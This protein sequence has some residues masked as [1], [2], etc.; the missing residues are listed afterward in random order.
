MSLK[1]R[2]L[3]KGSALR[4]INFVSKVVIGFVLMPMIMNALGDKIY[5]IWVIIGTFMG[6]Y[7]FFDFGL[8]KAAQRFISQSLGEGSE[9]KTNKT[10]NIFLFL[11]LLISVFLIFISLLVILFARVFITDLG[12]LHVFRIVVLI[13][14]ISLALE[15]PTRVFKGIL[16]SH[17]RY[18]LN[19]IT[20][21]VSDLLRF[22]LVF[23]FV[24]RGGGIVALGIIT[25]TSKIVGN[26]LTIVFACQVFKG[27]KLSFKLVD[28][29]KIKDI[30][31]YSWIVAV[32]NIT[33]MLR[34]RISSFIIV[35][36]MG[37][38]YVTIYAVALRLV[39]YFEQAMIAISGTLMPVFSQY[40]GE[41]NYN[42]IR[43][44][45]LFTSKITCYVSLFIGFILIVF[46]KNF[47]IKW[48][49]ES[50]VEAYVPMVILV[51][52][53]MFSTMQTPGN[54][55]LYGIS[56]H[57]F[58][59]FTNTIEGICNLLL[60]VIFIK[61][62][63]LVGVAFGVAIPLTILKLIV[64]P[65]YICKLIG[66]RKTDYYFKTVLPAIFKSCCFFAVFYYNI[67]SFLSPN[68]MILAVLSLSACVLFSLYV[69]AVGF[70]GSELKYLKKIKDFRKGMR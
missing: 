61:K 30:F 51:S 36:F 31:S 32:S 34:F 52:A 26:I 3:I 20:E 56:K 19:T 67:K 58:F 57:K 53:N 18:D 62:I 55:L 15:F 66:L 47:I 1:A 24:K 45:Y 48:L 28:R 11:Y 43:E 29:S 6:Y 39:E 59:I 10:V 44:K 70:K 9:I 68:Y 16:T 35:G 21:L 38:S 14:S 23:L 7:G 46:G 64:Q 50:Y 12:Y 4:L 49:G 2:R 8:I 22:I 37:L 27:L 42:S 25:L 33:Q 17:L 5:G 63:G 40:E 13:L 41:K 60:S 69:L 65:S 54:A